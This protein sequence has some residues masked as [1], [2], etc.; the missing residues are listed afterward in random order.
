MLYCRKFRQRY[1][2]VW[3][4]R[5]PTFVT[6]QNQ[7]AGLPRSFDGMAHLVTGGRSYKVSKD[8]RIRHTPS[9]VV[10]LTKLLLEEEHLRCK[11]FRQEELVSEDI[12]GEKWYIVI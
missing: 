7:L 1:G 3:T 5:D 9:L 4:A 10:I 12:S 8:V 2:K 11:D 6:S